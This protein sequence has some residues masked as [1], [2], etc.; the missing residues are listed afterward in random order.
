MKLMQ[1]V[2]AIKSVRDLQVENQRVLMRVDFNVP[3]DLSGRVVDD[4]RIEAALPTIKYLIGKG[5]KVILMS[6]LGRPK[7]RVRKEYTLKPV[8]IEL[9]RLLGKSV[10]F[11]DNCIGD[12]TELEVMGMQPGDVILLENLRFHSEEEAN[13]PGFSK[14]LAALADVY[15]DDAFGT[16]HRA[17][18]STVGVAELVK[19]RGI[20]F[21]MENEIE[22]LTEILENPQKPFLV[23][24]GGAKV[25]DK[26]GV[27]NSLLDKADT[28]LIGGAMAYTFALAQGKS[29]GNSLVER[30]KVDV[31][32]EC[33]KKAKEKG[34]NILLPLDT[35]ATDNLNFRTHKVGQVQVFDGNIPNGW[36]GVDIGPK[37]T[38]RYVDEI[39]G[40]KTI[41]WNGPMGVFE[42]EDCSGGTTT[43]ARA[44][45]KSSAKSI[46]GGGDSVTALR[47]SGYANRVSFISTGGGAS[48]E[49]LE[50]KVLPGIKAI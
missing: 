20:G 49:F 31:A 50:G 15:V 27:I 16:A 46:V 9:G 37:T 26:I 38:E 24:L 12:Y 1:K 18:A 29:V 36:E 41:L 48:L 43:I 28:M 8:A 39:R 23:I 10:K 45:G 21:L 44:I 40:A 17:H 19:V 34:V 2:M 14:S 25:S 30:D 11:L 5:A 33:L 4:A 35:V 6:H 22:D 42:I 47:L 7:G 3:I 13:D 32:L